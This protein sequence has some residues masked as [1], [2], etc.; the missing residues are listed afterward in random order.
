MQAEATVETRDIEYRRVDGVTLVGRLY[1]PAG[2]SRVPVMIEVHGG[3][4]T[5]GDRLNNATINQALAAAGVAVF[6]IDFRMPPTAI[7]PAALED[8]AFAIRWL[9]AN[10]AQF[11]L[12]PKVF[13]GIGTSSGGH[14]L[15][16][17]LLRPDDHAPADAALRSESGELAFAIAC[18]PVADPL[19]RY[20]MVKAKGISNL[21]NAH[22][23][24][25][26]DEA[27][28]EKANPQ[29]M[30]ERD[31]AEHL[32]PLLMLQ[33]TADENVEHERADAFAESYRARGGSVELRKYPG[34]P[35]MFITRDP[36]SEAARDG[37]AA[38]I[39]FAR[40]QIGLD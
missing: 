17:T 8:V 22:H 20:R 7:Y 26:P 1:R 15:L 37:L 27:A 29:M 36:Q 34:A 38:I 19:A 39:A 31:E 40:K 9:K 35:H 5:S 10:A 11:G 25:W 14:L 23:A 30:L 6:A 4:W 21:I 12:T 24:F 13:G 2:G 32:P 18:W 3:G 33:G 16:T 28:M